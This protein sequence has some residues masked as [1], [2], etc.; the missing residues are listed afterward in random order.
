MAKMTLD[1]YGALLTHQAQILSYAKKQKLFEDLKAHIRNSRLYEEFDP[2]DADEIFAMTERLD[3][4]LGGVMSIMGQWQHTNLPVAPGVAP[5]SAPASAAPVANPE[6][7][8]PSEFVVTDS[9]NK[10]Y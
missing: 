9:S 3:S 6:P 7:M 4:V 5:M 10:R 8:T 1:A 2:E